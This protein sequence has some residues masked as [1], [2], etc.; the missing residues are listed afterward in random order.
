MS[1]AAWLKEVPSVLGGGDGPQE[2]TA[3][4][5][6]PSDVSPARCLGAFLVLPGEGGVMLRLCDLEFG[7]NPWVT[8]RLTLP[9]VYPWSRTR[10]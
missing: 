3:P 5:A 2:L 10:S 1:L 4:G 9:V 7:K 6:V 8:L